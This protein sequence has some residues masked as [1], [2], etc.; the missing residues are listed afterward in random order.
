MGVE[1][2]ELEAM[3]AEIAA[4][5][6]ALMASIRLSAV[7][8][9]PPEKSLEIAL[10]AIEKSALETATFLASSG[11]SKVQVDAQRLAARVR[12]LFE[13]LRR[14]QVRLG[15]PRRVSRP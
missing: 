9:T 8:M 7:L 10:L 14:D 5:R 12:L 4:L 1:R 13:E 3:R 11:D 15:D 2:E 6:A